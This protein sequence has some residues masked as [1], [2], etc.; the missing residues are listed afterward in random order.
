[1]P[2]ADPPFPTVNVLDPVHIEGILDGQ[3]FWEVVTASVIFV[4]PKSVVVGATCIEATLPIPDSNVG[5]CVV[6]D[7]SVILLSAT[8]VGQASTVTVAPDAS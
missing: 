6:K 4:P 2:K 8:E 7:K 1:M 5:N 3:L